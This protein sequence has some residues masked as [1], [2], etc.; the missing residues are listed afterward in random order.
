LAWEMTSKGASTKDELFERLALSHPEFAGLHDIK[1]TLSMLR[2]FQ[3]AAGRDG[4]CRTPIWA[5][6]TITSRMAPAGAAYPFTTA[7]WTRN[8]I[9]P[10][11]G[12]V[13]I[14][15]DFASMEFGV[16]AGLSRCEAMIEAYRSGDPYSGLGAKA[17]LG[18]RPRSLLKTV[19]ISLPYGSGI[20]LI[21][22]RLGIPRREAAR[23]HELHH[24]EFSGY[25]A[26]SD[27]KLGSFWQ[28][29]AASP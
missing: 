10:N 12:T 26:W 23:L 1:K 3:L 15:L 8:L 20:P 22:G 7:S 9:T 28:R 27:R 16:A 24:R 18:T 25:W 29:R 19:I 13:L 14:Y 21:M 11:P 5:F 17:N 6:S 4:R 2:E